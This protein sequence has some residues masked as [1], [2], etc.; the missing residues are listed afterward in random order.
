MKHFERLLLLSFLLLSTFITKAQTSSEAINAGIGR[1]INLGNTLESETEGTWGGNGPA[2]EYYFDDYKA[3][4]FSS[5]RIPV[6][7]D[8]HTQTKAPYTIDANWMNRVEQIVDWGLARGFYIIINSHHDDWIKKNYADQSQRDRYDSIWSQMAIRFQHKSEKL[9]FEI[10]NE[11]NGLTLAQVNELNKRVLSIIRKTNPTRTVLYSGHNYAGASDMMAA[12]IPDDPYLIAYF[13]SYDPWSFAGES[14]GT[15]G[16]N[17]RSAMKSRFATIKAWSEKN[18]IPVTLNE[19]GAM[20]DCE[21]N[22]RMYFYA[23]Y[24]EDALASNFSFNVWDDGGWFKIYQRKERDWNDIK[25]IL[26]HTSDSSITKL[27]INIEKDTL[28][29]LSWT[30]R[31]TGASN[32]VVERRVN[33]EKFTSYA[34]LDAGTSSFTDHGLEVGKTYYYRLVEQFSEEVRTPSY[35]ISIY[36]LPWERYPYHGEAISIP[37]TIEAEDYDKGGEGLTYHDSDPLNTTG[38]YRPDEAVD[39]QA[40][41]DGFHVGYVE[42]GEWMEYTINIAETEKYKVTAHLASVDGGGKMNFKFGASTAFSLE[43]P[44]TGNWNTFQTVERDV[45]LKAGEQKLRITI[46][47]LPA[48]NIDKIVISTKTG[49]LSKNKAE[50]KIYQLNKQLLQLENP[51]MQKGTITFYNTDGKQLALGT[52]HENVHQYKLETVGIILYDIRWEDNGHEFGKV[53]LKP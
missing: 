32:I 19:F 41:T 34:T 12:A 52:I 24:V 44:K 15:W 22:S 42:I 30:N 48:F 28:Y 53:Q 3:A 20:W 9:L 45:N 49:I 16:D 36:V 26:I 25:D 13:H 43:A 7:W 50:S 29:Q 4:G 31:S 17:E 8:K 37:G 1:G 11:P 46:Q 10:I 35:P 51:G 14:K 40:R 33:N 47:A 38:D 5:V 2:Q 6:R 39:V 27:K 21:Y 18:N 23:S